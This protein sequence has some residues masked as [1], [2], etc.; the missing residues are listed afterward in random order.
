M[1]NAVFYSM[2]ENFY[3]YIEMKEIFNSYKTNFFIANSVVELFNLI[4][5]DTTMVI[6][7]QTKRD[8]WI[9]YSVAKRIGK[10]CSVV[11]Y[12]KHFKR[13]TDFKTDKTFLMSSLASNI[14][15]KDVV[16]A[17]GYDFYMY[18]IRSLLDD[19]GL[20]SYR[21][22]SIVISKILYK[23]L[24]RNLTYLKEIDFNLICTDI[25]YDSHYVGKHIGD[26][27]KVWFGKNKMF[28]IQ[29][30]PI[31]KSVENINIKKILSVFMY[32]LYDEIY[33]QQITDFKNFNLE[34]QI[35]MFDQSL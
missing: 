15:P 1:L 22:N 10:Y 2:Q 9:E 7:D 28:T 30:Y 3:D 4:N 8:E 11:Y 16:L 35:N 34:F 21:F 31:F 17:N 19:V 13:F 20:K 26:Y 27:F 6:V 32:C 33:K 18:K 23:M 14:K 29:K 24:V 5:A 12:D 25:G